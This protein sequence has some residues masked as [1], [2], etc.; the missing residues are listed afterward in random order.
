MFHIV[1]RRA[2]LQGKTQ[3]LPAKPCPHVSFRRTVWQTTV[4]LV[5]LFGPIAPDRYHNW[6]WTEPHRISEADTIL[7]CFDAAQVMIDRLRTAGADPLDASDQRRS[8]LPQLLNGICH[9]IHT[10]FALGSC[11]GMSDMAHRAAAM[12]HC[13]WKILTGVSCCPICLHL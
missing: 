12:A 8:C 13:L 4:V 1:R 2:F 6:L 9:D 3:T 10:P 7:R 11:K 5:A